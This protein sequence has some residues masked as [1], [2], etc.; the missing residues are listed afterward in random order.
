MH[1]LG[2]V[3]F[4]IAGT[5]HLPHH[6]GALHTLGKATDEIRR[7]FRLCFLHRHIYSHNA[8]EH[9]MEL[10]ILQHSVLVRKC[11]PSFLTAR[12]YNNYYYYG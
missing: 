8:K 1:I 3:A 11:L 12:V 6:A 10:Y 2:F 9:S 5:A 7:A 4:E